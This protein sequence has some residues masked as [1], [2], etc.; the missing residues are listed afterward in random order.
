MIPPEAR[1]GTRRDVATRVCLVLASVLLALLLCEAALRVLFPKY[2]DTAEGRL[3]PDDMRIY[4]PVPN[5]RDWRVH[6]DT[7]R[8]HPFHHNNLGLRQHRN[9]TPVDLATA[10]T[11][12]VFGDSFVQSTALDAPHVFT[13]PLDYL[14]N[15]DGD[16]AVLNFGVSGY[17]PAQSYFAYRSFREKDLDYMLFVYY[18]NN[19]IGDLVQNRLFDLDDRG[20]LRQREA[21]GSAWWV[22]IA[23]GL[24]LTYLALDAGGRLKPYVLGISEDLQA[25]R[26]TWAFGDFKL[27][28]HLWDYGLDVFSGANRAGLRQLGLPP[29]RRDLRR[30]LRGALAAAGLS[31]PPHPNGSVRR[32]QGWGGSARTQHLGGRSRD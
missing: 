16:F 31:H 20:R 7:G 32:G 9:F 27:T 10:T 15:L 21:R 22:P 29:S 23:S 12:G 2:R 18:A 11:V 14:L 3:Q 1:E 30:A 26:D 28:D 8:S 6:P 4:A 24:H 19:D 13:E 5:S 17:G 25:A